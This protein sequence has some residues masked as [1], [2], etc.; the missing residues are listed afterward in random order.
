MNSVV[1]LSTALA[2]KMA[3]PT[4]RTATMRAAATIAMRDSG[5]QRSTAAGA[6]ALTNCVSR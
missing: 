1:S 3:G 4:A 6:L 2:L 5:V